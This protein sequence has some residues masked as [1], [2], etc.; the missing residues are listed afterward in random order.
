MNEAKSIV[1][2]LRR[3]SSLGVFGNSAG[4]IVRLAPNLEDACAHH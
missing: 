2:A 4:R 3:A 1:W